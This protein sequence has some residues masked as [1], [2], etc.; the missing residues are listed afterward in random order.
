VVPWVFAAPFFLWTQETPP[1]SSSQELNTPTKVYIMWVTRTTHLLFLIACFYGVTVGWELRGLSSFTV[2]VFMWS[3]KQIFSK[4][5]VLDTI[6]TGDV[7]YALASLLHKNTN[8]DSKLSTSFNENVAATELVILFVEPELRTDQVPYIASAYASTTGG[9]FSH[10]QKAMSTAASTLAIPYTTVDAVS[11]FDPVLPD[12]VDLVDG[13][14]FLSSVDGSTLFSRLRQQDGIQS[15][16]IDSLMSTLGSANVFDNGKTDLVIVSF[17]HASDQ[18]DQH[19]NL[20]GQLIASIGAKGNY[21][22]MYAANMPVKNE[23][24]W[25]FEEHSRA[26]FQR[27]VDLYMVEADNGTNNSNNSNNSFPTS[28]RIN[29][30][31]GP[32]IE[33]LLVCAILITM[34]F[35]GACAIFSLQTPDKWEVPKP[36]KREL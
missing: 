3:D 34:L 18:F 20:I 8:K 2:P 30:F 11:L 23:F 29:Y 13:R 12:L 16:A 5:Q 22:A 9:S 27:N 36:N 4:T 24:V 35:T 26:E 17:A 1:S 33:A 15:V 19:D 31:P 32:F 10:L 28:H 7:E 21:V 14:V 6:T 25:T